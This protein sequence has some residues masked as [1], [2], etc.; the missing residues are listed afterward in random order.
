MHAITASQ[1]IG[2]Q[3]CLGETLNYALCREA[4]CPSGNVTPSNQRQSNTKLKVASSGRRHTLV[5]SIEVIA[6]RLCL[7]FAQPS[8][9]CAM[10]TSGFS[11]PQLQRICQHAS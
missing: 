6:E 7:A 9:L 2:A 1:S 3:F 5:L 4:A 11:R 10:S 8:Q